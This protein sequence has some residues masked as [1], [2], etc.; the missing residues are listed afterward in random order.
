MLFKMESPLRNTCDLNRSHRKSQR[1]GYHSYDRSVSDPLAC[2][3]G[4]ITGQRWG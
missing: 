2:G 1:C 4:C 3:G